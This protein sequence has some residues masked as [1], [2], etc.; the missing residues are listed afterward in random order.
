MCFLRGFCAFSET[1]RSWNLNLLSIQKKVSW[2]LCSLSEPSVLDQGSLT[3]PSHVQWAAALW[4]THAR[5]NGEDS[6]IPTV[7]YPGNSLLIWGDLWFQGWIKIQSEKCA[8]CLL[9][10]ELIQSGV[11]NS[12]HFAKRQIKTTVSTALTCNFCILI[13]NFKDQEIISCSPCQ[14]WTC[15]IPFRMSEP[16][17]KEISSLQSDPS[18]SLVSVPCMIQHLLLFIWLF[19]TWEP[20][21]ALVKLLLKLEKTAIQIPE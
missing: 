19:S 10:T 1:K 9:P 15:W 17:P 2:N 4:Q 18:N 11:V 7:S 21:P 16:F 12:D 3:T 6:P 5:Q 13:Q 8:I 14:L 20:V